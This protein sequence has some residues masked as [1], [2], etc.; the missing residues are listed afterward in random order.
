MAGHRIL[1]VEDEP[2]VRDMIV[3]I[4]ETILPSGVV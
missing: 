1:A 3:E 2:G 4:Q